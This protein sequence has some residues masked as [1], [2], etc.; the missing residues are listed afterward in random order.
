MGSSNSALT[1]VKAKKREAA[2]LDQVDSVQDLVD[3]MEQDKG[4][5][6]MTPLKFPKLTM[7]MPNFIDV[8]KKSKFELFQPV[9][10]EYVYGREGAESKTRISALNITHND[11]HKRNLL[12]PGGLSSP[13]RRMTVLA[14]KRK[15]G[16]RFED[17]N[18]RRDRTELNLSNISEAE[19]LQGQSPSVSS[20]FN[21]TRTR[22]RKNVQVKLKV[23][24]ENSGNSSGVFGQ[25]QDKIGFKITY[26]PAKPKLPYSS[27]SPKLISNIK[28]KFGDCRITRSMDDRVIEQKKSDRQVS[29]EAIDLPGFKN[30]PFDLR[31]FLKQR[32]SGINREKIKQ[33][34]SSANLFVNQEIKPKVYVRESY[35]RKP[36]RKTMAQLKDN[37]KNKDTFSK[38]WEKNAVYS[39]AFTREAKVDLTPL[40]TDILGIIKSMQTFQAKSKSQSSVFKKADDNRRY[41]KY[42]KELNTEFS[43]KRFERNKSKRNTCVIKKSRSIRFLPQGLI[44]QSVIE[45]ISAIKLRR[46]DPGTAGLSPF[47]KRSKKQPKKNKVNTFEQFNDIQQNL[48]QIEPAIP[49]Q[50]SILVL[51][52]TKVIEDHDLPQEHHAIVKK[53]K[54]HAIEKYLKESTRAIAI[55]VMQVNCKTPTSFRGGIYTMKKRVGSINIHKDAGLPLSPGKRLKAVGYLL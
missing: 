16:F 43:G 11:I 48:I 45:P 14:G 21:F 15:V 38:I 4:Y 41:H 53:S 28:D 29:M 9:T 12:S 46:D 7:K 19:Y 8:K 23:N 40:P 54:F 2:Y 34:L 36:L 3:K 1:A 13:K 49:R 50:K 42:M 20:P 51:T 5:E 39:S 31:H 18:F 27:S 47:L 37:L 22:P 52:P 55:N 17:L 25:K 6:L 35:N 10:N 30:S 32:H 24:D 33:N 26:A 44:D